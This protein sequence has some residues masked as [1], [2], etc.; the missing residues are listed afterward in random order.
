MNSL[1]KV[2]QRAD[3]FISIDD[4]GMVRKENILKV[5]DYEHPV[6]SLNSL[7]AQ[8]WLP[9][10]NFSGPVYYCGSYFRYGFHE[11]AL[12]SAMELCKNFREAEVAA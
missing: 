2:S 3:Y 10:L 6:F 1:Q 12:Q 11:D 4:P 8:S 7:R 9:Q 5:M